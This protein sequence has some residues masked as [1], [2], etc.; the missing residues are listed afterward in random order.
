[1]S[2][3][4][5]AADAPPEDIV[6]T[7][8]DLVRSAG[9][10]ALSTAAVGDGWPFGSLV[11]TACTQ[12]GEPLLLLSDLA[13]HSR[14]IAA[15]PRASLLFAA[16]PGEDALAEARVAVL[17]RIAPDASAASR[18]RYLARQPSASGY[19][20][21]KDFRLYRMAVERAHLVA[22]FGRIRWLDR[23]AVLVPP[24]PALAESEAGI[25]DHMNEDHADAIELYATR[26]LGLPPGPWRMTGIDP[27]GID[28][29]T[30][31]RAARLRFGAR[32]ED[33]G[34]ARAELVRL[35]REARRAP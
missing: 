4:P 11:A 18:R 14:N 33:A 24:A 13:E 15:D 21:F 31:A 32:I 8:R 5:T 17:G 1:M 7:A 26:L 6:R 22:G 28:L 20:D 16:S 10:A 19:V 30:D 34:A 12:E 2:A 23:D 35:V 27:E 3:A 9:R 29:A 25:V